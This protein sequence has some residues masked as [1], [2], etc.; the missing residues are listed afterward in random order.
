MT[1]KT[2]PTENNRI[3]FLNNFIGQFLQVM[4]PKPSFTI[5][6]LSFGGVNVAIDNPKRTAKPPE[7]A[8][9]DEACHDCDGDKCG[10]VLSRE[11]FV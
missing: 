10:V 8:C 6:N 1:L 2:L 7:N 4:F 9:S 11:C 3:E 5:L